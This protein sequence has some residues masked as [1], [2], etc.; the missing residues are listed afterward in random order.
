V[1]RL[2]VDGHAVAIQPLGGAEDLLLLEAEELGIPVAVALLQRLLRPAGC[3]IDIWGLPASD[4][5]AAMLALRRLL[6]GE[7]LVASVA[8][9]S[10]SCGSWLD[11]RFR[12]SDYLAHHRPER[13][14]D[15]CEAA[16]P[17]WFAVEGAGATFRLPTVSDAATAALLGDAAGALLRER[18][19][20]PAGL[21]DAAI[22]R[23]EAAM[24]ALA[25]CL[26]GEVRG[27][28][29]SC[30]LEV[31]VN[32][33]PLAFVL[34]ELRD[35]SSSIYEEVHL[36]ASRYQWSEAEILALPAARRARYAMLAASRGAA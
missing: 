19:V 14:G 16:E 15:V 33:D 27:T 25:P 18:C 31:G 36:I 23:V 9:A 12:V 5:D 6:L 8:C 22:E 2:P 7:H 20:R 21:P 1:F 34:R 26:V 28:C 4:L 35:L 13:P 32:F 17:G 3:E 11:I 30:G 24:G 10:A 29:P